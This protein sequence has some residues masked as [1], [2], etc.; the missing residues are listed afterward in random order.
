MFS[1]SGHPRTSPV[2]GVTSH[3]FSDRR[4]FLQIEFNDSIS[5]HTRVVFRVPFRHIHNVR[6]KNHRPDPSLPL[7]PVHRR[8]RLVI[9]QPV[10]ASD[11]A[12][13]RHPPL[14]VE[15]VE[16]LR[17]RVRRQPADHDHVARATDAHLESFLDGAG[18]DEV[19]VGLRFV[20]L[21]D[22]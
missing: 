19:L 8:H 10:L 2:A 20:E 15:H 7:E 17:R 3:S 9:L 14:V 22:D 6:L 5:K 18:L 13:P 16:P 1:L 21:T 4:E 12:E 11:D